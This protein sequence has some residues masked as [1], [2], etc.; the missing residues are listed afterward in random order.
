LR[1][2]ILDLHPA[3]HLISRMMALRIGFTYDLKDDYLAE[4]FSAEAAAEFDSIETID[5]IDHALLELG[6]RTDRI[7]SARRLIEQLAIG[8]RWDLVFNIAEGVSG[9]ARE[10]QVPAILDVY[11]IPY[12]FSDPLTLSLTLHKGM[13]KHVARDLGIPTPDFAV[14]ETSADLSRIDLPYPLF[15]KPVA[16][17]TSKGVTQISKII[18]AEEL[19][20]TCLKLLAEYQ[21]PVIVE[22]FLPGREFTV[23]IA[24]TG[25]DAMALGAM[26]VFFFDKADPSSYSYENK[27][28]WRERIGYRLAHDALAQAS[29]HTALDAW[30]GLGCRDGGRVDVRAD[31]AGIPNFIEVN[32]LAGLNPTH[33][34]LPILAKLNGI[35]YLTLIHLFIDSAFKRIE[36]SNSTL[37]L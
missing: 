30:K 10:A 18:S 12:V 9:Y 24:G 5:A 22:T 14:I 34:D 35:D 32:P 37:I 33:S 36:K 21:Q 3:E 2:I 26:E 29:M 23:G 11:G 8:N 15:A 6:H 4:G 27:E 19:S 25:E 28:K 7:G 31:A 16:E 17:G 1:L 20:A 13:T